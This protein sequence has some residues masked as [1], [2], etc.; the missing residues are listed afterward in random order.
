MCNLAKNYI[1]NRRKNDGQVKKELLTE[2]TI[3]G[4]R[5][6]MAAEFRKFFKTKL[7][8]DYEKYPVVHS[9]IKV[10]LNHKGKT[11]KQIIEECF[12]PSETKNLE[13]ILSE[14]RFKIVSEP[15]RIFIIAFDK[16][17]NDIGYDFGGTISG[18]KDLM[19][20]IYGKT[21]TKSR[22]CPARIHIGNDGK[23]NL[24]LYLHKVDDHRQ[25]IENAPAHVRT[26]FTNN[27][28]K[29]TGCNFR[30]G[31]C[32]YKCTK[33]YTIGGRKFYKCDF[34]ITNLSVEN[35]SDYIDLI[36]E[37]YSKKTRNSQ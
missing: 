4:S 23:I 3:I 34:T 31:K 8:E 22:L 19:A 26:V 2:D 10:S 12:N 13:E 15:D 20:I 33:I 28:G 1:V 6:I 14:N 32:K 7:G 24:R 27:V 37:F 16:A 11:L 9:V 29:C 18:N 5:K 25:Y 35:I 21:G 17:M 30:D 36:S